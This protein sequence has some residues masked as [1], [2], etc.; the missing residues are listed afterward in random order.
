MIFLRSNCDFIFTPHFY[1]RHLILFSIFPPSQ[2]VHK[3]C[4]QPSIRLNEKL[5]TAAQR[6]D[7]ND[8]DDD[9]SK[10]P[11][12]E[13]KQIHHNGGNNNKWSPPPD[14]EMLQFLS[15]LDRSKSLSL[16]IANR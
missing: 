15:V 4:G 10:G 7:N 3:S 9:D 5:P 2:Q 16:Q 6:H 11:S 13:K 12:L 1:S 14:T 8:D